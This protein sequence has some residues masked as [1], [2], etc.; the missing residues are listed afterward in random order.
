MRRNLST[1]AFWLVLLVMLSDFGLAAEFAWQ[2]AV[3]V[4]AGGS[5]LYRVA[6]DEQAYR[7][8]HQNDLSDVALFD[9]LGQPLPLAMLRAP[10]STP[11]APTW[12]NVD[13]FILPKDAATPDADSDVRVFVERTE[14]GRLRRLETHLQGAAATGVASTPAPGGDWLLDLGEHSEATAV[15]VSMPASLDFDWRLHVYGSDDVVHWRWLTDAGLL[16]LQREGLRLEQMRVS[17][18]SASPRYLRLQRTDGESLPEPLAVEAE[19]CACAIGQRAQAHVLAARPVEARDALAGRFEYV[20]AGP[21]PAD[22]V[23]LDLQGSAD[24]ATVRVFSRAGPGSEWRWRG[25][26]TVFALAAASDT[27]VPV[28]YGSRDREWRIESTPPL[29][30][31]PGLSLSYVPDQYLLM[32]GAS[33][34][35]M[36]ALGSAEARPSD[37]PLDV[38]LSEVRAREGKDWLPP[39][40]SLGG[41]SVRAGDAA[42]RPVDPPVPWKRWLLWGVLGAGAVSV[43]LMV[44]QLLRSDGE[45]PRP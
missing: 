11:S 22:A 20:A 35:V 14:D 26:G 6:L 41:E 25:E 40:L 24:L 32:P 9:G 23:V 4:P 29:A 44:R 16:R 7:R 45:A 37:Y 33:A 27:R 39:L 42:L 1:Q 3:S 15:R 38:A 18:P 36:L 28:Q 5:G 8:L 12:Q 13:W 43:L 17:L 10:L 30:V 31:A 2:R 21:F 34:E 19:R